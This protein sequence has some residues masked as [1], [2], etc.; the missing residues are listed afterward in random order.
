MVTFDETKVKDTLDVVMIQ[1]DGTLR[2]EGKLPN[3]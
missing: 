2:I 1:S 3:I